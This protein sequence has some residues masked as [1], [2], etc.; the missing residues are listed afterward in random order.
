MSDERMKVGI[1]GLDDM[2]GGGLIPGSICAIIGTYGTG[3]TTF[4]L[5]FIWEGLKKGEHIIYI[6]LEERE[7]RIFEY[8]LQKGWDVTPFMNKSLFVIK[9]DPT[10][11][12]L[13]NNRIKNELP[14]LIKQVNAHRVVIDPISL[15][16]DLFDSDSIRRQEMFR[17]VESMRDQKCTIMMTSETDKDNPFSSRHALIEYLADTVIL[18]RYVRPSDLTDVHLALEVVKMRMSAHSREI[19]PYEIQ[20]DQV[21]VYSE[22]NVF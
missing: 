22:A 9:L 5:Q 2:L 19:K 13:A 18:L 15:F 20:Q 3:K 11:F 10:D 16:E 21:L 4:A 6:S 17:F 12:N 1:I 8:M 7:E 14:R